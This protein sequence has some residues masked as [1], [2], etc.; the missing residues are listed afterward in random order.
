MS[1]ISS[2]DMLFISNFFFN[3]IDLIISHIKFS[4]LCAI[5]YTPSPRR[6]MINSILWFID[7]NS[8]TYLSKIYSIDSFNANL[9]YKYIKYLTLLF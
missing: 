3:P 8:I 6:S 9:E 2:I 7:T 5:L 1:D 4:K